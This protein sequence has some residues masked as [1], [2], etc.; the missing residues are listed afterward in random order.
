MTKQEVQAGSVYVRRGDDTKGPFTVTQLQAFA[1]AGQIRPSDGIRKG[2]SGPW[3]AASQVR[4]L[5]LSP[6]TVPDPATEPSSQRP[7]RIMSIVAAAAGLCAVGTTLLAAANAWGWLL[8]GA[9]VAIGLA[10]LLTTLLSPNPKPASPIAGLTTATVAL[11]ITSLSQFTAGPG[12]PAPPRDTNRADSLAI[13]AAEGSAPTVTPTVTPTRAPTGAPAAP[14]GDGAK[15]DDLMGRFLMEIFTAEIEQAADRT[16]KP[17]LPT[18]VDA[19]VAYLLEVANIHETTN[20]RLRRM[21]RTRS[22][23]TFGE[24]MIDHFNSIDALPAAGVDTDIVLFNH[25]MLR[26]ARR[27][28]DAVEELNRLWKAA[29]WIDFGNQLDAVLRDREIRAPKAQA[30]LLKNYA[31][32]L[33][34]NMLLQAQLESDWANIQARWRR[35][36]G[37]GLWALTPLMGRPTHHTLSVDLLTGRLTPASA[38]ID[39][40]RTAR[41]LGDVVSARRGYF[42]A[43]EAPLAKHAIIMEDEG[44]QAMRL[45]QYLIGHHLALD[46]TGVH[47]LA[48]EYAQGETKVL[49]DFAISMLADTAVATAVLSRGSKLSFAELAGG[50]FAGAKVRMSSATLQRRFDESKQKL[51]TAVEKLSKQYPDHKDEFWAAARGERPRAW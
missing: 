22:G 44:S 4:G 37:G 9:G 5:K 51:R 7:T 14:P 8:S 25:G 18:S 48:V 27:T 35:D 45:L 10:G 40:D 31:E 28:N 29:K 33:I 13:V 41:F 2:N 34:A 24:I 32:S 16:D 26:L 38:G 42:E 20:R 12:A 50:V 43:M 17:K 19:T 46:T 6:E 49:Q 21:E 47:P 3:V 11:I 30:A 36:K 39:P 15:G 1:K 23:A